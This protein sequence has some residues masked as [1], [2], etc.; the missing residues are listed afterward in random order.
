MDTVINQRLEK[1]RLWKKVGM[2]ESTIAAQAKE[3]ESSE[4]HVDVDIDSL[5]SNLHFQMRKQ[6]KT[7]L[8][9]PAF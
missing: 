2:L 6:L 7:I 3:I 5:V 9:Y 1:L 4:L 8:F